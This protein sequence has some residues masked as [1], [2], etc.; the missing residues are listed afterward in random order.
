MDV[1]ARRR[2]TPHPAPTMRIRPTTLQRPAHQ[3][4]GQVAAVLGGGVEIAGG[5]GALGGHLGRIGGRGALGQR[6]LHARARSGVVPMLTRPT[7]EAVPFCQAATPT[8]A[9]SWARR[10]NFWKP[11][12]APFILGTRISV[13]SSVGSMVDSRKPSEALVGDDRPLTAGAPDHERGAQ[14]QQ[15]GRQ[16][17]GGIGVGRPSRRSCP[18]THLVVAH[19]PG[20]VGEQRYLLG[21]QLAGLHV[22]MAGQGADGHVVAAVADVGQVGQAADVDEH[23]RRSQAQLHERQQRV[24][25]GQ[26]LGVVAVLGQQRQGLVDRA[27]PGV[28]ERHRDHSEPPDWERVGGAGGDGGHFAAAAASTALTML[29]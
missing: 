12:V 22:A 18:V 4:R 14:R 3:H 6:L 28:L 1:A 19:V 25:A 29:W 13:S 17:G 15:G 20:G 23:G 9:Q 5:L 2:G 21:Q 16:V 8:M 27:R 10:L 26:E 7:P 11:Q 24:A